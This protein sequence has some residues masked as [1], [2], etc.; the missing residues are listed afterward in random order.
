MCLLVRSNMPWCLRRL[1]MLVTIPIRLNVFS[2]FPLHHRSPMRWLLNWFNLPSS[3]HA[4]GT[5][6]LLFMIMLMWCQLWDVVAFVVLCNR[7]WLIFTAGANTHE[8]YCLCTLSWNISGFLVFQSFILQILGLFSLIFCCTPFDHTNMSWKY[9]AVL[10]T[11]RVV[12]ETTKHLWING[13]FRCLFGTTT[14]SY[15]LHACTH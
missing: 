6:W 8:S 4:V 5:N 1:Q 10:S 13:I 11:S 12:V 9:K 14:S 3:F 15:G 2:I 7:C